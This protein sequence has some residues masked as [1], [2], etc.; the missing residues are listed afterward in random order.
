M[1][2]PQQ[3]S[4]DAERVTALR[5][6]AIQHTPEER[7][8]RIT[9]TA[10]ALFD[11]P[12]VLI[13]VVESEIAWVKSHYGFAQGHVQREGA[14]CTHT[15][16]VNT[17]VV[18]EDTH[19]ER[20]FIRVPDPVFAAYRFYAGCPISTPDGIVVG[21]ICL[22]DQRPR[23][24]STAKQA[25][26]R[27]VAGWAE[28]EL[29]QIYAQRQVDRDLQRQLDSSL[30]LN[31]I[32]ATTTSSLDQQ[33]VL[34]TMCSELAHALHIPNASVAVIDPGGYLEVI[35]HSRIG[36]WPSTR[37]I[38]LPL[39]G[40]LASL[41]VINERK[42][43]AVSNVLLEDRLATSRE[44]LLELGVRAILIVP[45]IV[46]DQVLGTLGLD[47]SSPHTFLAAEI[48]LVQQVA[49]LVG[50]ALE[51]ARLYAAM[52]Q[53]LNERHR[54]EQA[55]RQ[56]EARTRA[57]LDAVPDSMVQLQRDGIF[58]DF[59]PSYRSTML[60]SQLIGQ[61]LIDIF[62]PAVAQQSLA[63]LEQLFQTNEPQLVEYQLSRG[64]SISDY[65]ARYVR[66]GED[67]A[68]AIIR[69]ITER[70]NIDRLKNEFV[71]VV[72]HELRTPLT[73]IR[74]SLGLLSGGVAGE[75]S[76]PVRAMIDIAYSNSERLVRLIND[77][78]DIEKIESGKLAF[79]FKPQ[80]LLPLIEQTMLDNAAYA[81]QFGVR[82]VLAD[83]DPALLINAD[84]DRFVQVL[85]NL[86]SN[87]VKFSPRGC[88]VTISYAL[89][90]STVGI[91]VADC[92]PGISTAFQL[93][94]FQKFAQADSSDS[95]QKGGTGLG[96]SISKAIV[97]KHQGQIS[98][99]S[100]PG[101]GTTF[102]IELPAWQQPNY[103]ISPEPLQRKRV[104]V[105]EDDADVALLLSMM[106]EDAGF[107]VDRALDA[108]HAK[109][110]LAL[111]RYAAMTVDLMLPD[112][113]GLDFIHEVRADAATAHL[114][115]LVI[116]ARRLTEGAAMPEQA[117]AQINW[118]AKPIDRQQLVAAMRA[119]TLRQPGLP[120]R[121]LHVEDD[122]DIRQIVQ[123][124]LHPIADVTPVA[125]LAE[126][127]TALASQLFDLVI[128]DVS[129]P[130][131]SGIELLQQLQTTASTIPIMIFS[132]YDLSD[133]ATRHAAVALV[134]S[135]TANATF[136]EKVTAL[137]AAD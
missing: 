10:A 32:L 29:A 118:L 33:V 2:Q 122:R 41:Y 40:N 123:H 35:A 28:S 107:M 137:I 65:E 74:G 77:I 95:R 117:L 99:T 116:S 60:P 128:L 30:L 67:Q 6:L 69:D 20:D 89:Q 36:S 136:L 56:S 129:L 113:N 115:I 132:A 92:G 78:L 126:A 97:E 133:E 27:D 68:L 47:W 14:Y 37:G 79:M 9:R 76:H 38:R 70:K 22:L 114:P 54:A 51:R 71:S 87:A 44:I 134:K 5:A 50:Q 49:R 106:L 48:E 119:I 94:I 58:L 42:P 120:S 45:I 135:Q 111:T 63:A 131:G 34:D 102:I 130:D 61:S 39:A 1:E 23:H 75:L 81:E 53:E 85:T 57:L 110:L 15:V 13:N 109:Q 103:A 125:T 93:R 104:L 25:V 127:R 112:Q 62:P 83:H 64:D 7:F 31:Q 105:V 98:F 18:I 46:N 84:T 86:I 4:N 17:A 73:S 124:V 16:L 82:L 121:I 12:I 21:T 55:L 100:Q 52:Q 88:A 26:L 8:D 24:F 91:W 3:A 108:C 72:S 66:C 90:G 59:K 11:V 101:V 80:L 19:A 96:L 43:L